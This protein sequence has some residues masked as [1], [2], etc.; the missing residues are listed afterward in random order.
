MPANTCHPNCE[1]PS[2]PGTGVCRP[3]GRC[4]CW[5]GWT[6]PGAQWN[7]TNVDSN[8]IVSN[9]IN[10]LYCTQRCHYTQDYRYTNFIFL[11]ISFFCFVS[12]S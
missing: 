12:T 6:G 1:Q 11:F 7:S 8:G 9:R 3:D 4:D 2:T 10:A 5:W